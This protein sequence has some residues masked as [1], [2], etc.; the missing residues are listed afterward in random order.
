MLPQTRNGNLPPPPPWVV[1]SAA[2]S[3]RKEVTPRERIRQ[4]EEEKLLRAGIR[5]ELTPK[6]TLEEKIAKIDDRMYQR[7]RKI[8][9]FQSKIKGKRVADPATGEETYQLLPYNL[10]RRYKGQL[11]R[12]QKRLSVDEKLLIKLTGEEKNPENLRGLLSYWENNESLPD[13]VCQKMITKIRAQLGE[14]VDQQETLTSDGTPGRPYEI[15]ESQEQFDALPSGAWFRLPGDPQGKARRKPPT[16]IK[17]P[18]AGTVEIIERQ[19]RETEIEQPASV[20][21]ISKSTIPYPEAEPNFPLPEGAIERWS[22]IEGWIYTLDGK[23]WISEKT[24]QPIKPEN[25]PKETPGKEKLI[26]MARE[27]SLRRVLK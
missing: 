12:E 26:R 6:P 8:E 19:G 16:A 23:T 7:M 27:E 18:G 1:K 14:K 4:E 11:S 21:E 17:T 20:A 10:L 15:Q 22:G 5:K 2:P 3:Q 24:G 13:S 9:T 25:V